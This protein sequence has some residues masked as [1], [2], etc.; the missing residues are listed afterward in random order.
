MVRQFIWLH[1]RKAGGTSVLHALG[2]WYKRTQR[3]KT[4]SFAEVPKEEWNDNLNNHRVSLGDYDYRRMLYAKRY[5]Y[6]E[7]EFSN[8]FKFAVVRN[9]YERAVSSWRYLTR[10]WRIGKPRHIRAHYSFGYFLEL[11]PEIWETKWDRHVATHTAP[12]WPDI[13]DEDGQLLLNHICRL[14]RIQEDFR[15]VCENLKI[16]YK[17]FP[18][19]NAGK[20]DD[21]TKYYNKKTISMI[22]KYYSDDIQYLDYKP[23]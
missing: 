11:L 12:I 10:Q 17:A 8:R 9:P 23:Y 13:T 16:E 2:P 4:L 21:F 7:E 22:E 20:T 14:E 18:K 19:T 6:D 3:E 15:L 5:L 1:I